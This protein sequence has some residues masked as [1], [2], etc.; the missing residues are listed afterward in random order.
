MGFQHKTPS[1]HPR[2]SFDTSTIFGI[3]TQNRFLIFSDS[4]AQLFFLELL[5]AHLIPVESPIQSNL[6]QPHMEP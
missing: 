1:V 3:C 2:Y 5:L 6:R 4:L